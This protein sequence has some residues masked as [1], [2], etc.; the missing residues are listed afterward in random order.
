[1]V[2]NFPSISIDNVQKINFFFK[3]TVK[4]DWYLYKDKLGLKLFFFGFV[5]LGFF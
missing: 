4:W 2:L 5:C 1:M 3:F